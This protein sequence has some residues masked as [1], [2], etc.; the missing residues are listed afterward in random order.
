MVISL[1]E[2]T[3]ESPAIVPQSLIPDP[4]CT[5]QKYPN[6]SPSEGLYTNFLHFFLE[7]QGVGTNIGCGRLFALITFV[8][9]CLCGSISPWKCQL[10]IYSYN[11]C[12]MFIED[13]HSL[14]AFSF[15][16]NLLCFTHA[17]IYWKNMHWKHQVY[18]II[19]L[20]VVWQLLRVNRIVK[21]CIHVMYLPHKF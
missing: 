18:V 15:K 8:C 14:S 19:K 12:L 21:V 5:D 17:N 2:Q 10:H 1:V 20:F 9:F 16:P 3:N 4:S 11:V 7:W 6:Q 13:L